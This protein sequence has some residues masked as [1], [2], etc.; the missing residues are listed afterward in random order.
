MAKRLK[1]KGYVALVPD[2]FTARGFDRCERGN[3][4]NHVMDQVH[5]TIG[6]GVYLNSLPFVKRDHLGLVGFS[7]GAMAALS[8]PTESGIQA[9]VSYYPV[10]LRKSKRHPFTDS[11]IPLL[12]LLGELDNWSPAS[13][14]ATTAKE[15][16][17]KGRTIEW[18]V[19]SGVH[20]GFDSERWTRR[21]IIGGRILEYDH[22]AAKDSWKRLLAFLGQHIGR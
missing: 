15:F 22:G 3:L 21:K 16:K 5:D 2:S 7:V 8:L 13:V 11:K 19:Y 17:Q 4:W 1:G 20:H 6:A 10:C 14:C 12:L 9:A 18:K